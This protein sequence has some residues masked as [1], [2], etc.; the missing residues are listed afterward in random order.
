MKKVKNVTIILLSII[1]TGC[2]NISSEQQED[3]GIVITQQTERKQST[4]STDITL[5][6]EMSVVTDNIVDYSEYFQ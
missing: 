4:Q 6:N 5:E 3:N 1:V 2:S